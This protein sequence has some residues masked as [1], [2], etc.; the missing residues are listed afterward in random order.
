MEKRIRMPRKGLSARA[1]ETISKPGKYHDG[2]GLFLRVMPSGSRQ[3]LQRLTIGGRR[4]ELGL[5]SPPVVTLAMARD[6]AIENRRCAVRGGDPLAEKRAA[7]AKASPMT[8][9]EAVEEYA[10]IKLAEF[11]SEK[12]RKQWRSALDRMIIPTL[13]PMPVAQIETADVLRALEQHWRER[14]ASAKKVRGAVEA[15]LDWATVSGHRRGDNPARWRGNL[16]QILP[17]PN[18]IAKAV[19]HPAVAPGDLATWWAALARREGMAAEALRFLTLTS[20]RSGEVRGATWEEIDLDAAIW[21]ISGE[22][23]KAGRPHRVPLPPA[24]VDL[25][26]ALPRLHGTDL[27]FFAARGGQ[28]SDMAIGQLMRRMQAAEEKAGRA[29]FV[30]AQTGKPAVAHG[31]RSSFRQWCAERGYDRDLAEIALAH[32][33]G[34]EVERAYQRSDMLDRRRALLADWAQVLAGKDPADQPGITRLQV[35]K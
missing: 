5:G 8:F 6:M 31:L 15:V 22:R 29:G 27:V 35:A 25:L 12:H 13:G 32:A 4:R 16:A 30:D 34:S 9:A 1:V 14:T 26:R 2:H 7:K 19:H 20:A 21:T 11:K 17:S 33:V 10:K 3:W 23:M 18:K 28:L 24:A